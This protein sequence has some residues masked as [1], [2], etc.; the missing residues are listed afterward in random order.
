ML[1]LVAAITDCGQFCLRDLQKCKHFFTL[2]G[3]RRPL[4]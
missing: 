3:G 4:L 1:L 2:S